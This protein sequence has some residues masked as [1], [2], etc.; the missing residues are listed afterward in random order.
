MC[1]YQH[2]NLRLT[3]LCSLKKWQTPMGWCNVYLS[4]VTAINLLQ[5][6]KI[7]NVHVQ[8]LTDHSYQYKMFSRTFFFFFKIGLKNKMFLLKSALK[9][10]AGTI[11]LHM[12]NKICIFFPPNSTNQILEYLNYG[13]IKI[14]ISQFNW[15]QTDYRSQNKLVTMFQR[16]FGTKQQQMPSP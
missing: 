7:L 11:S 2:L 16:T 14:N 6:L 5:N 13:V 1:A 15:Q 3:C 12:F 8:L 9:I 4:T 10:L